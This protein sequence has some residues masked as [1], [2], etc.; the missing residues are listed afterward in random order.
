MSKAKEIANGFGNLLKS[1]VGL[2]EEGVESLASARQSICS[3]CEHGKNRTRCAKCGCV[4]AA[5]TRSI[6]S[7]CP[8]NLW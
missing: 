1:K 4:L 6:H 8:I 5:K 2:S 3:E 7:S